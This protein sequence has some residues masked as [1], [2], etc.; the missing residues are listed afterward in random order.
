MIGGHI[1]KV[2]TIADGDTTPDVKNANIFIT[3]SNTGA[4]EI[5]DFDNPVVGQIITII[6]GNATNPSTITDSGNFALSANWTP[7]LD[8]VITLF[9]KADNDYI[10]L[11]RSAN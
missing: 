4:T 1:N 9:V 10:E 8:D 2:V 3:S 5:T 11:S 7:D 6:I